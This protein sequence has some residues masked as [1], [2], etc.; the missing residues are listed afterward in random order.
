MLRRDRRWGG[1]WVVYFL[2]DAFSLPRLSN[3]GKEVHDIFRTF[4]HFIRIEDNVVVME[5]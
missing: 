4:A 3:G 5:I 1:L 2:P